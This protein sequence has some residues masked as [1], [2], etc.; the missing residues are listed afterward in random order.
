MQGFDRGGLRFNV[1]ASFFVRDAMHRVSSNGSYGLSSRGLELWIEA[2]G[3]A[4]LCG[5]PM[6]NLQEFERAIDFI[7][8]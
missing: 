5:S 3:V 8:A 7:R 2:L 4:V 6:A 1:L